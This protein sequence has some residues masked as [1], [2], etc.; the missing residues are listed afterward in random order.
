MKNMSKW[1]LLLVLLMY[2]G[3][4]EAARNYTPLQMQHQ[5]PTLLERNTQLEL[6]F[7]VPGLD[8]KDVADAYL[9]YRMDGDIAYRQ[10]Q[11]ALISS[12]FKV[13]I[14]VEDKQA[15]DVEY[16]FEVQ[17][18]NGETVT[19]PQNNPSQGPI[20]VDVVDQRKS[21]RERRVEKT[22]VDYTILSPDPD[23]TVSQGDVVVALTLFYDPAEV[24][25]A[26]SSFQLLLDGQD[27]T[28]QA[29]ASDYF[30]TYSPDN[31]SPG[32]HTAQFN[33]IRNDSSL[34]VTS[35]TFSVLDPNA[36]ASQSGSA[37]QE[38]WMPSGRVQL[39]ARNQEVGGIN[40]DALSGNVRLSG[41]KGNISYSA[42]GLLTSQEDPRL[43]PQNR[44]G[45]NLYIGNWLDLE[46]GHVYPTLSALTI[47]GQRMQGVNLGLHAW[48]EALSFRFVYGKLRRGI[49]NLYREIEPEYQVQQ[50]DT[51]GVSYLLGTQDRGSGTYKRDVI[52][53][54][55]GVG[56]GNNFEFG[57]NFLKVED[58]TNSIETI[59]NFNTLM[60]TNPELAS[61][62]NAQQRD[63]L[64]NNPEQ[65]NVNGN[66][67]PKGNFVAATDL[68]FSL[69]SD[70]IRFEG[71]VAASLL[72]ENISEGAL[73]QETAEDLGLTID[74]SEADLLD[75]LSWLI[76]INEN[77]DTLPF[78]FNASDAGVS[79]EVFFPTSIVAAQSRLGFNYFDNNL[80][81]QYRWVG[82]GYN[83]LAN[84]TIRK[85]IAGFTVSDRIQL[86][87]NRIY[88]TLG[89][90]R[91]QDNVVNNKEATTNTVTYRGTVSWY[92][93]DQNLPR[94]SLSFLNRNRDNN[95]ALF[96]PYVSDGLE[97]AAVQNFEIQDGDTLS[98][99]GA[100]LT[101]SYQL[102]SSISQ[103]FSLFGISHDASVSYSY[104]T[105]E[106]QR[107]EYGGSES[108]SL[109]M[110]VVNRFDEQPLQTTL[111]FNYNNTK[112]A[113]GLTDIQIMGARIGA[114]AFFFDDKLNVDASVAFT[115]NRS[116]STS[117]RV[118]SNT[119]Q[120]DRQ[121]DYYQPGTSDGSTSVSESN[122]YIINTT[123]RYN[124]NN[125]HSLQ[126]NFRYSNIRNTISPVG[127][128]NDHLLQARYIFNF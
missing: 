109:S 66:P 68:M 11:A 67:R 102:T 106:D 70:R 80:K 31:L 25:T 8:A 4:A 100:R 33:I 105:T 22:G 13:P 30:Y 124:F 24:D 75:Q 98:A 65:L 56:R 3:G 59:N 36:V 12:Q 41:Q 5:A 32:E 81:I 71:D 21:E 110:Q 114:S 16:Y 14:T 46:A 72:N 82:P 78:R 118:N 20:S 35:W 45:G 120:Q 88:L 127:I 54:R 126:V 62:L 73:S 69:D 116:E 115:K 28:E 93:L 121:D 15:T 91:L 63:Q 123:A 6:T 101:N 37:D 17:L 119:N 74:Q 94:V 117:L 44:F 97:A 89:Y 76:I 83:S 39:S 95:V 84:S 42:Y 112:T 27:V 2:W 1:V 85:D 47:A 90:E 58:D 107:F 34:T 113:N 104:I 99:P 86:F 57:L 61:S 38:S 111:G 55:I 49:D 10:Q 77:M 26:S 125:S 9:F 108:T 79:S 103:E 64:E 96:N 53:G 122:S 87:Q 23:A 128:P 7:E 29:S 18:H 51:V 50:Q 40:N 48:N 52:G 19:Y 92:P 60:A 43:Q